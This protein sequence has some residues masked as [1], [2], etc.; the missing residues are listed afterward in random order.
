MN[1]GIG[2]TASRP[3][4]NVPET[5]PTGRIGSRGLPAAAL[6]GAFLLIVVLLLIGSNFSGLAPGGAVSARTPSGP[7]SAGSLPAPLHVAQRQVVATPSTVPVAPGTT[8]GGL[9]AAS[10]PA[11]LRLLPTT[12][13]RL[14]PSSLVSQARAPQ[15]VPAGASTA[16]NWYVSNYGQPG[17]TI[18]VGSSNRSIANAG[19][20]SADILNVSTGSTF[21]QTHGF[22]G[23]SVSKNG[24]ST[25]STSYPGQN[26]A[27]STTGNVNYGDVLGGPVLN[28]AYTGGVD[29]SIYMQFYGYA[30]TN[31]VLA[32]TPDGTSTVLVSPFL[33]YCFEYFDSACPLSTYNASNGV[34]AVRSTTGGSTWGAPIPLLSQSFYH[35]A[36]VASACGNYAAGTYIVP[37]VQVSSIGA[38]MTTYGDAFAAY[39]YTDFDYR[40]TT[41]LV[42][43]TTVSPN[44]LQYNWNSIDF[45]VDVSA[46]TNGGASWGTPHTAAFFNWTSADLATGIP[47]NPIFDGVHMTVGPA[48]TETVYLTYSDLT[49]GSAFGATAVGLVSTSNNG[50]TWSPAGDIV[51]VQPNVVR[52][53]PAWFYNFSS[54]AIAAD[55]WTG[56]SYKGNLYLVW[57][58]NRTTT[59]V[60]GYPSIAFTSSSG[61]GWT[62]VKYLSPNTPSSTQYFDPSVS[63]GASGNVWVT[64]YGI[65]PSGGNYHLYGVYSTDG[66]SAWSDQFVISDST[67]SPGGAPNAIPIFGATAIAATSAGAYV[68]WEDCRAA[69]CATGGNATTFVALVHPVSITSTATGITA[70][71]T[72]GGVPSSYALP[73]ETGWDTN[74][75]VT[76]SVPNWVAT[77]NGSYIDEFASYS[78]ATSS[79]SNPVT[80]TYVG[81]SL[82]VTYSITAASWIDGTVS[83]GSAKPTLSVVE[84]S[85]SQLV[86]ANLVQGAGGYSY[87]VTVPGSQSYTVT[88]SAPRYV[89]QSMTVGTTN[90]VASSATFV[91]AK[92]NG[93]IAGTV[94]A[95]T[96]AT[97]L[98][99]AILTINDTAIPAS[100]FNRTTGRFNVSEAWGTYFVNVTAS[101][102][103]AYVP[104]TPAS[105]ITVSPGSTV[106]VKAGLKGAWINGSI[107]PYPV[108][109]TINNVPV[110]LTITG[111]T[112]TWVDALPGGTYTIVA[113]QPGYSVYNETYTVPAG[114]DLNLTA[115]KGIVLTNFGTIEGTISPASNNGNVPSLYV[116][117]AT[118]T[119]LANGQ[120][121]VSETASSKAYNVS[122]RL[123]GYDTSDHQVVV[124]PGNI[125]WLNV[126]LTKTPTCTGSQCNTNP[127]NQT[128]QPANCTSHPVNNNGLTTLDYV[129]I[130]VI[131]LLVVLIAAVLLMRRGKGG[132]N[133]MPPGPTKMSPDGGMPASPSA[134]PEYAPDVGSP[135]PPASP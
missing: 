78:G 115:S 57:A 112:A 13:E 5:G 23:V 114:T 113:K 7:V 123:L 56:S 97:G 43:N 60:N 44:V 33:P 45:F 75:S 86:N 82:L 2:P 25:W 80:F 65:S 9:S 110:S 16:S 125:S 71:V 121:K 88:A 51:G 68:S 14:S 67:S 105:P 21:Y 32:S 118:Q 15:V 70:T 26:S 28:P 58:D 36:P 107:T 10:I 18:Q 35:L 85:T 74:L 37:N 52:A 109:V 27:W 128:P 72:V 54:P 49:N 29:P 17:N 40:G 134:S 89:T 90:H 133:P 81:G 119:V 130:G 83:A 50:T 64:Y 99:A 132:A 93:W 31:P 94:S 55:N 63:V 22:V 47:Y 101:P 39:S 131:V 108:S 103:S 127:C 41:Y 100:D 135:P 19:F 3:S 20:D 11:S 61:A 24:G 62:S 38:A 116:N 111:N 76:V 30:Q 42:C 98:A 106:S 117:N 84:I 8:A 48:P 102:S 129:G 53:G 69:D 95:S 46:S 73:A 122:V 79:T 91:L 104:Y 1:Q 87:N 77:P 92:V 120:F 12:F 4:A 96:G 34:A 126:T 66:G 6:G 124:T 59:Q